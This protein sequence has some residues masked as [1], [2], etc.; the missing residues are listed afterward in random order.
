MADARPGSETIIGADVSI[1]GEISYDGTMKV[2]GKIEGKIVS[3]GRLALG[4][5]G[6]ITADVV[7][8]NVALDGSFKGNVV[9]SERIELTSSANVMGDIRAPKLVIA[10]GATF[11][12]NC[13]VSPDA[14]KDVKAAEFVT[15]VPA[16]P[17]KK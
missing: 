9:A 11:V 15:A 7:V 10:E 13:H 16:T 2:E 12:G 5:G 1:K 4:K 14:L 3:K 6:Q 8:G 17:I